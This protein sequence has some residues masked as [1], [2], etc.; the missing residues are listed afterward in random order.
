M[1]FLNH[2]VIDWDKVKTLDDV[3]RLVK[4]FDISFEPD[5]D[6]LKYIDDL[7]VEKPK[8]PIDPVCN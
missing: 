6:N 7:V 5:N 4:A 2:Y 8:R 1:Y 3:K